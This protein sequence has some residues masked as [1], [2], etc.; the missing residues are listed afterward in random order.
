MPTDSSLC[1][2][3]SA[4]TTNSVID[5]MPT[6]TTAIKIHRETDPIIN[7]VA[8]RTSDKVE[9]SKFQEKQTLIQV[10]TSVEDVVLVEDAS[11]DEE[12]G[13]DA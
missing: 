11:D 7:E 5:E 13:L 10:A 6:F 1:E 8:T 4:N 12:A 3:I 2:D 9:T